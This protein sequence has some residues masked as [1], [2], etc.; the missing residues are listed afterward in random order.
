MIEN[1]A[2]DPTGTTMNSNLVFKMETNTKGFVD[3]DSISF[4]ITKCKIVKFFFISNLI[5]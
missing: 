2:R 5:D 1:A 4:I 3:N